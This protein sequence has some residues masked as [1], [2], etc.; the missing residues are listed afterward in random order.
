MVQKVSVAQALI[1][2]PETLIL[3]EPT[4]GLDPIARMELR[5]ILSDIRRQGRTI[6]FSSHELSE[7]EL[8]CDSIAIIKAGQLIKSGSKAQVL[9]ED[10]NHNLELFFL[11]TIKGD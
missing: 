10:R 4:A 3:D 5:K 11:H 1:N 7:V 8:L 6:F 2:E 9:G